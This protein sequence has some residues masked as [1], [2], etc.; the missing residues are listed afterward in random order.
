MWL[1][2][3]PS[4]HFDEATLDRHAAAF[5]NPDYVDVVI[6]SYRHRLGLA[7]GHPAYADVERRLAALPAIAV[8]A[9]TLDG[10]VDGVVPATDGKASTPRFTGPRDHRV[11][12]SAG[13]NLPEEAPREFAD[14]VWELAAGTWR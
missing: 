7:Q 14:A 10:N 2:N 3:S 8:P 13:H 12:A 4:W 5:D 6:H 9:I 1:R 11:I